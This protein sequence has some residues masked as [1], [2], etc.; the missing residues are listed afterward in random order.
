MLSPCDM[1]PGALGLKWGMSEVNCV[2][3][4][5]SQA[6]TR[7]ATLPAPPSPGRAFGGAPE[8]HR[9]RAAHAHGGH[10]AHEP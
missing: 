2:Q 7:R 5:G 1:L 6:S 4:L 9:G 8:L 10:R 3:R